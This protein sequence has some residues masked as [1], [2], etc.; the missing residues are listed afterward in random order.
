MDIDGVNDFLLQH[1][2]G[3]TKEELQLEID[4]ILTRTSTLKEL[5]S[6]VAAL[7]KQNINEVERNKELREENSKL[8]KINQA[9]TKE[10]NDISARYN[11]MCGELPLLEAETKAYQESLTDFE[12]KYQLLEER[13]K[14]A[15][16]IETKNAKDR[17]DTDLRIQTEE[18]L[19]RYNVIQ[20]KKLEEALLINAAQAVNLKLNKQ[21]VHIYLNKVQAILNKKGIKLDLLKELA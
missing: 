4:A 20:T 7:E 8:V 19:R 6:T 15:Q 10:N 14:Q 17:L 3:K 12:A 18:E 13:I 9:I 2:T 21:P 11:L 5:E 1:A 16:A